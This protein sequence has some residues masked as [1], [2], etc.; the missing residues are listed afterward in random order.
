MF[1]CLAF[2]KNHN[3]N[4][5]KIHTDVNFVF[6]KRETFYILKM[7]MNKTQ[8]ER[9]NTRIGEGKTIQ[10]YFYYYGKKR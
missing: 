4:T 3:N 9:E 7:M 2:P 6:F 8:R 5:V 10:I 1:K